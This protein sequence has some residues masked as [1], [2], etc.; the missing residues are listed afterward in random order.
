MIWKAARGRRG[1]RRRV[2]SPSVDDK[3]TRA[4][5][6]LQRGGYLLHAPG[7]CRP[8]GVAPPSRPAPLRLQQLQEAASRR[9][10]SLNSTRDDGPRGGQKRDDF[11]ARQKAVL[12]GG[13]DEEQGAAAASGETPTHPKDSSPS[14]PPPPSFTQRASREVVTR[15]RI[16]KDTPASSA[17]PRRGS[18][19]GAECAVSSN[20]P[21]CYRGTL[22]HNPSSHGHLV[23]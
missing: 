16:W 11:C 5:L 23:I 9:H 3:S 4:P 15:P 7:V 17:V 18:R 13:V 1:R 10:I 19:R 12:I 21:T 2:V 14:P 20:P 22:F 8:A 6:R